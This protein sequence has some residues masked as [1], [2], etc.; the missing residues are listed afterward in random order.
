[1]LYTQVQYLFSFYTTF[2][3]KTAEKRV[4]VSSFMYAPLTFLLNDLQDFVK[5]TST[6]VQ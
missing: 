5:A 1:M 2:N 3:N 6:P 4:Q